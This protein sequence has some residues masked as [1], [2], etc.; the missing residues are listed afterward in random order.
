MFLAMNGL[1]L[2][3]GQVDSIETMLAVAAGELDERSLAAW[4]QKNSVPR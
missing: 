3:A 4:I 1:K 2:V